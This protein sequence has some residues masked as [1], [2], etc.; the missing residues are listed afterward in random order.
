MKHHQVAHNLFAMHAWQDLVPDL[1]SQLV[2]AGRGTA[3]SGSYVTA[4]KTPNGKLGMAYL[5][6]A[7]TI[8]VNLAQMTLP[9]AAKWFDPT[10]GKLTS[11]GDFTN[12][13]K[14]AF[15]SPGNNAAGDTDWVLVLESN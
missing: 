10:N 2:T 13:A 15:T 4:A 14:Q 3:G 5:P 6:S 11:A 1:T 7:G 8:T 9:L 12:A